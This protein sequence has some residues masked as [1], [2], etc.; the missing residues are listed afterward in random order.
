MPVE[1]GRPELFL[2]I[3]NQSGNSVRSS[4]L[5]L[6]PSSLFQTLGLRLLGPECNIP[7]VEAREG[8]AFPR[9]SPRAKPEGNPEEKLFLP[10]LRRMV[11]HSSFS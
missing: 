11:S 5:D 9:N 6:H 1:R 2:R 4:T 3:L 7:Y 8:T 10:E